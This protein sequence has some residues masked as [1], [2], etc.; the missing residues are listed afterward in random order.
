MIIDF[1]HHYIPVELAKR[2][3]MKTAWLNSLHA[4]RPSPDD[5]PEYVIET[6]RELE[7]ILHKL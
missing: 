2:V 4:P 3:G 6:L 5:P 7:K 1:E